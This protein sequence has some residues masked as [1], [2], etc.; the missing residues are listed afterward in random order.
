MHQ[1]RFL[2]TLQNLNISN[3]NST[4]KD[5]HDPVTK[6][7]QH[8]LKNKITRCLL[9]IS[10]HPPKNRQAIDLTPILTIR[11]NTIKWKLQAEPPVRQNDLV[12]IRQASHTTLRLHFGM[13]KIQ[14]HN[15][16]LKT[17]PMKGGPKRKGEKVDK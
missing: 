14:R 9:I 8:V 5:T 13:E 16:N 15:L 17:A 6:H 12:L 1:T 2:N 4:K 3:T 7:N 11:Q 10:Q